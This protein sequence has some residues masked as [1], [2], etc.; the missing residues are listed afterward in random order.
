[1]MMKLMMMMR[2]QIE[3]GL[4][5]AVP[6][7]EVIAVGIGINANQSEL[8]TIASSEDN[9]I[10]ASDVVD[11]DNIL[12]DLLSAACDSK[13]VCLSPSSLTCR[14]ASRVRTGIGDR[15]AAAATR[16]GQSHTFHHRLSYHILH[17]KYIFD[18]FLVKLDGGQKSS[19]AA[20]MHKIVSFRAK[21]VDF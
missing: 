13:H 15:E 11:L 14:R 19:M 18:I 12:E 21:F 17:I 5:K 20:K 16:V 9:V 7:T 10:V 1:M 8:E 6:D 3:A 2:L 4:L